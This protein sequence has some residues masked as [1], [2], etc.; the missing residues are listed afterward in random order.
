MPQ[1]I[2]KPC[3]GKV[4]AEERCD[5]GDEAGCVLVEVQISVTVSYKT[6]S[7][8]SRRG[9]VAV[10]SRPASNKPKCCVFCFSH[11]ARSQLPRAERYIFKKP[12]LF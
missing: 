2:F 10:S 9:V 4:L 11:A 1:K 7:E 6:G 12:R 5:F 8:G 3:Q